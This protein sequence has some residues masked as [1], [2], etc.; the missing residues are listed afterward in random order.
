[1]SRRQLPPQIR[2]VTV[3]DRA[4]AKTVV[5]YQVT[6]DTGSDPIRPTQTSASQV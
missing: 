5:R 1:M 6:V 2:K 4:T 3:T